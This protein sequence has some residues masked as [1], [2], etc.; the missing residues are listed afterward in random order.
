MLSK[1]EH[2]RFAEVLKRVAAET[3]LEVEGTEEEPPTPLVKLPDGT[4]V[5]LLFAPVL[6]IVCCSDTVL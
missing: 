4:V 6:V 1:I 5:W 2:S 3:Y